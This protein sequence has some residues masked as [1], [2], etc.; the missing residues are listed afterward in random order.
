MNSNIY[1]ITTCGSLLLGVGLW[2]GFS[3][4]FNDKGSLAYD[5]NP[6]SVKGSP[7]GKVLALAMQGPIDFYWHQGETHSHSEILNDDH[8][9]HSHSHS[10]HSHDHR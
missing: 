7:Y 4:R 3:I 6:A 5:S 9:E 10:G 1:R 2:A 8:S